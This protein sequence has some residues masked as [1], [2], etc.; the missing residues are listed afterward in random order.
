MDFDGT[1]TQS[2]MKEAAQSS[3]FRIIKKR[4]KD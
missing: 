2:E 1:L 4:A 3:I